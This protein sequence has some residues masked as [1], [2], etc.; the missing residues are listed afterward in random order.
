MRP[1][2]VDSVAVESLLAP[3]VV[4]PKPEFVHVWSAVFGVDSND[5]RVVLVR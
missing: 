2:V 3:R 5:L 4:G 1:R